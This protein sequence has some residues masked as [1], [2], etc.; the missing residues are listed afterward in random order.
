MKIELVKFG[1]V[2]ISRPAGK[3]AFAAMRPTLAQ[4]VNKIEIDFTGVL[5]LSPSWADEFFPAIEEFYGMRPSFLPSDNPS[6]KATLDI[7]YG[8]EAEP[9]LTFVG[10]ELAT[11]KLSPKSQQQNR[12]PDLLVVLESR[13]EAS[14]SQ[15]AESL[16]LTHTSRNKWIRRAVEKGLIV[17]TK[18][19]Q[20]DPNNSYRLTSL[21]RKFI[22]DKRKVQS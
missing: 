15:I 1:A 22:S 2:L 5:S 17:A 4:K 16:C 7:L 11:K 6:V 12:I 14:P 20:F 8:F 10:F 3:E 21:G 18:Q 9:P 13:G 19:S